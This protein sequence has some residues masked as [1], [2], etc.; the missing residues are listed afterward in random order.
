MIWISCDPGIREMLSMEPTDR[1][2]MPLD[3]RDAGLMIQQA[4][5]LLAQFP[6]VRIVNKDH[7]VR[8]G[9]PELL[10][11]SR[12]G[13]L[14]V[15]LKRTYGAKG[16]AMVQGYPHEPVVPPSHQ[17]TLVTP[18]PDE[19][20]TGPEAQRVLVNY[21]TDFVHC[22]LALPDLEEPFYMDFVPLNLQ[23]HGQSHVPQDQFALPKSA[24]PFS[25][26]NFVRA[27]RLIQQSMLVKLYHPARA[28]ENPVQ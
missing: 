13:T 25:F 11:S 24:I 10:V 6:E 14:T 19:T 1:F 20:W 27:K 23:S 15:T 2:A 21:I 26:A 4:S 22:V 5:P 17:M 16:L 12:D 8:P 28:V 3:A 18:V 7:R 9:F